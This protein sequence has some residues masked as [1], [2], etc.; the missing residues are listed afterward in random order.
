MTTAMDAV[1]TVTAGVPRAYALNAVPASP[2]YPYATYSASL[3]RGDV[4]LNDGRE[5]I[6]WG[7]IVCQ[8]FGKT[9]TAADA[10]YEEV[11]AALVGAVLNITG[12]EATAVRGELDPAPMDRDSDD[13]GVAGLTFTFTFTATKEA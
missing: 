13:S 2:T 1:A 4:Y 6:R 8:S 9:A 10:K 12:Y 11:R 7:R 5:G 3:G